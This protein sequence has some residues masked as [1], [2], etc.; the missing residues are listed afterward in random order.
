MMHRGSEIEILWPKSMREMD[1]MQVNQGFTLY[2]AK[3]LP[4]L[5]MISAAPF[6]MLNFEK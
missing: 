4:C 6:G 2:L 1:L 5:M 3:F